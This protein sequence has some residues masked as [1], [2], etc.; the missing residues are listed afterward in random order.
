LPRFVGARAHQREPALKSALFGLFAGLFGAVIAAPLLAIAGAQLA[1]WL[2]GSFEG[3]AA[4]GGATIGGI[5]GLVAG[6]FG[7]CVLVLWQNGRWAGG[8][9]AW[10][11][12]GALL[13][14]VCLFY[15]A[16]S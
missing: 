15:V 3:A 9:L 12:A 6:F 4:M 11:G 14:V 8:A 5:A 7:G 13:M 1:M 16:L 2:Y 10:L